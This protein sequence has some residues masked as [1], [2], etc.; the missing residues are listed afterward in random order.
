MTVMTAWVLIILISSDAAHHVPMV[1]RA[2]C[3]NARTRL[4]EAHSTHQ[5]NRRMT[6]I[7]APTGAKEPQ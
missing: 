6:Y 7:C 4:E 3:E 1:T 5:V 2:A